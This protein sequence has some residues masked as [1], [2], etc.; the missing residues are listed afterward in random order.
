[1]PSVLHHP[2]TQEFVEFAGCMFEAVQAAAIKHT[3]KVPLSTRLS[4]VDVLFDVE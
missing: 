1:M 3:L 4:D 2:F